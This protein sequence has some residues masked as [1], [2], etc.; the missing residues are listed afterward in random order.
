M[1]SLTQEI[2]KSQGQP[3]AAAVATLK[4]HLPRT[5]ILVGQGIGNDVAWLGLT[6]GQDFEVIL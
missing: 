5:A 1:R 4:E 2:I 6:E 3:L